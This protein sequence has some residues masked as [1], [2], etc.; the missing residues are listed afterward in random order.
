MLIV[1]IVVMLI[2]VMFFCTLGSAALNALPLERLWRLREGGGRTAIAVDYWI[3][4]SQQITWSL[5][6]ASRVSCVALALILTTLIEGRPLPFYVFMIALVITTILV[7]FPGSLIPSAWAQLAGEKIALNML[8]VIRIISIILSPILMVSLAVMNLL[9]KAVGH[10][11]IRFKPLSMRSEL[12]QCVGGLVRSGRLSDLEKNMIRNAFAF[13]DLHVSEIMTPRMRMCCIKE[14]ETIA[15]ACA[16][17]SDEGFS[18]M[19]VYRG[20][21]ATIVGVLYAKDLLTR[22]GDRAQA[23][24][25]VGELVRE[26]FFVPEATLVRTLFIEMLGKRTHLAVVVDEYGAA[27]GLVTMED[28]LEEVV[29]GIQ[30]EYDLDEE[31]LIEKIGDGVYRADARLSLSDARDETGIPFP[32]KEEYDTLGGFVC[33][34]AGR[35]PSAGEV[36]E[37]GGVN[38]K[39]LEATDRS[40]RRLEIRIRKK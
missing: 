35:I 39:V 20:S 34:T 26:P 8:P 4:H 23:A 36:I 10:G 21:S 9:L 30:D 11:P 5:R 38:I 37:C 15:G 33:A 17:F 27:V 2:S 3:T 12:E 28:I 16:R 6:V 32:G 25:G 29:G 22:C 31:R 19:P 14:G 24:R 40:V 7:A 1:F 18:R 13:G